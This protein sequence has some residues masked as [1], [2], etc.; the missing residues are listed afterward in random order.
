MSLIPRSGKRKQHPRTEEQKDA[1]FEFTPSQEQQLTPT[2]KPRS[3]TLS[4][5]LITG[6]LKDASSQHLASTTTLT[7][8]PM[9]GAV[10]VKDKDD[11]LRQD[12]SGTLTATPSPHPAE[13]FSQRAQFSLVMT[14][15]RQLRPRLD[16]PTPLAGNA[17]L[18]D[19]DGSTYQSPR[20][21]V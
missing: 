7:P 11:E 8:R 9:P 21:T 18:P 4:T 19:L 16:S 14:Q 6:R 3:S 13:E 12:S 17:M 2:K 15:I 5:N 20:M 1:Q 10:V